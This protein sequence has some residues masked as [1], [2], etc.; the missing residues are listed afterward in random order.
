MQSK[1]LPPLTESLLKRLEGFPPT[2][3]FLQLATILGRPADTV[4]KQDAR[5]V[6]GI[7]IHRW[8][9]IAPYALLNDVEL[10]FRGGHKAFEVKNRKPGRPSNASRAAEARASAAQQQVGDTC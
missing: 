10:F 3:S 4:R 1:K 6:L 8:P 2:V 7:R 5:G 9:G